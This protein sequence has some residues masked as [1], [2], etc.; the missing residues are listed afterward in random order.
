[1]ANSEKEM[2]EQLL[3]IAKQAGIEKKDALSCLNNK[4]KALELVEFMKYNV[5]NDNIT[6]TPSFI[7]NG[8]LFSNMSYTDL[9]EKIDLILSNI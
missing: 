9:K 2:I 1:M 5:E 6:S 3:S 7:I 8:E 4:D